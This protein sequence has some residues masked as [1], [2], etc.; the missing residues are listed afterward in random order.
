RPMP[1]TPARSLALDAEGALLEFAEG[2]DA[3]VL[4]P[5]LSQN[6]DSAELARRLAS[7]IALPMIIDADGL[8]AFAGRVDLLAQR[9]APTVLTPHPGEMARLT[10]LSAGEI[11]ADRLKAARD[12][13]DRIGCVVLLKGAGTVIADPGGEAWV[14]P[15]G[16]DGL[17]SGG[18]GD[19]LSG[20]IGAFLAGGSEALGAAVA[21][22]YYH[23]LAAEAAASDGVRGMVP[24]KLLEVLPQVFPD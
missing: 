17:A 13:A 16:N 12:L 24:P 20:M 22:A 7:E 21:G 10:E 6:A 18:S 8:N 3:V 15:T 9:P 5:G 1:E 14:N 11:Q 23:G 4:G 19:V 2:M